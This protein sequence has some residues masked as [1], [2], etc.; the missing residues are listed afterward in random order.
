MHRAKYAWWQVLGSQA[1]QDVLERLERAWERFFAKQGRPPRFK[2]VKRYKSF[3]LKQTAGWKLLTYNQNVPRGK[4]KYRRARG[5]VALGG[6][7]YK[8]VQHRPL[9]GIVKTVT[10]KRD[11]CGGL[12]V[13]FSVVEQVALPEGQADLSHIGGFDFGLPTFLT[14]HEGKRW[15]HPEFFRHLLLRLRTLNRAVS[16]KPLDSHNRARARWLLARTHLRM[17]DKRR[18][19][20]FKLAHALCDAFDVL[21]FED[22]NLDGMKRLWGR[23]V[24]DLG[25]GK[26]L[27]IVQHVAALR[28]KVVVQIG[29][30][31]RTTQQ[32]STCRTRVRLTLKQRELVCP[33]PGCGTVLDRDHNAALNIRRAGASALAGRGIASPDSS[34]SPV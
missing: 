15:M 13:C 1:V 9:F 30:Y 28:G 19:F 2:K 11:S 24:S 7:V 18:D 26:F 3:T 34:G 14:D 8:F 33:T 29:R 31:E 32:C 25:F 23:K 27:A 17:A 21:V 20:H 16:R 10:V 12:W 22:L 5:T 4:G 6:T